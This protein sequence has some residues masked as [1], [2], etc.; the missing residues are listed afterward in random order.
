MGI[1]SPNLNDIIKFVV[2]TS[3]AAEF[4]MRRG[5]TGKVV[6]QHGPM[7]EIDVGFGYNIYTHLPEV[8][9]VAVRSEIPIPED[10]T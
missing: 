7:L 2:V 9:V 1:S 6:G 4:C 3:E 10:V 8:E 5:I